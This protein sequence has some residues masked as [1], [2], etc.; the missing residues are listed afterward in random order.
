MHEKPSPGI[1]LPAMILRVKGQGLQKLVM[2]CG[3]SKPSDISRQTPGVRETDV[4][5]TLSM[6][7]MTQVTR[8]ILSFRRR[9]LIC[10]VGFT[11]LF[12]HGLIRHDHVATIHIILLR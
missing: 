10:R 12:P 3:H 6:P 11:A 9:L 8:I 1:Q 7:I 5:V 2:W 4:T